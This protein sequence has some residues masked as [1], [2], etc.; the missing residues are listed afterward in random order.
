LIKRQFEDPPDAVK[1]RIAAIF[2]T[3]RAQD[4]FDELRDFD[5]CVT[6]VRTVGEVAAELPDHD[7]APPPAMGEHTFEVLSRSGLA[8]TELEELRRQGVIA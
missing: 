4:W 8:R 2:R 1:A 7:G 3:K 5:C 6:E